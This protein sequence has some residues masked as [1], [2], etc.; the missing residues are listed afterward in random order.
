MTKIEN[1]S[2]AFALAL[3]AVVAVGFAGVLLAPG[4]AQ[5][6]TNQG[7]VNSNSG[8]A[9]IVNIVTPNSAGVSHNIYPQFNVYSNGVVLNNC[10]P[11]RL[12]ATARSLREP[13]SRKIL[14]FGSGP[15]L[16]I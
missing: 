6:Q 3:P 16:E 1:I 7:A 15:A 11:R 13:R 4:A 2:K 14:I 12:T 8:N 9:P 10:A 5:G